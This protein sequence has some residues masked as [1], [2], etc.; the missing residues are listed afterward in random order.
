MPLP[1]SPIRTSL[2][3]SIPSTSFPPSILSSP[4]PRESRHHLQD[5]RHYLHHR[6]YHHLTQCQCQTLHSCTRGGILLSSSHHIC[7]Y[8]YEL[9]ISSIYG[10][11]LTPYN[12]YTRNHE[13]NCADPLHR[14][15]M[16]Q[17]RQKLVAL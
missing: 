16:C 8:V 10:Q 4:V 5:R 13:D 1:A 2:S 12:S 3:F 11:C 15:W 6:F 17:M 14:P 7:Y 9:D